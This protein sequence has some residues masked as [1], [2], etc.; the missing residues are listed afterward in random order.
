M[1]RCLW[2]LLCACSGTTTID[3]GA[4]AGIETDAGRDAGPPPEPRAAY[5]APGPHPSGNVRISIEV[6]A[7]TLP[8]EL[9]YPAQ[10][11]ARAAAEAGQSIESFESGDRAAALAG[12]VSAAPDEC[13]RKT[14][15]S[16]AAP[17]AATLDDLPLVVFSHCHACTRFDMAEVAE[18]LATHGIVVAAP[19]HE[20]NTLWDE[21]AS[22]GLMVTTEGLAIRASDISGVLDR[23]LDPTASEVPGDLRGRFGRAAVMGH[24]FGAATTGVLVAGGD[25]R[26]VAG[27]AVAAPI[28][29]LGDV[30]A[31]DVGVPF[32]YLLAREDNSVQEIGNDL[33]RRGFQ[34]I[35][36]SRFLVEVDDA[37]HWSFSDIAGMHTGFMAGCGDGERHVT[38]EPFTYV[39]A[40]QARE[41]AADVAMGFFAIHLLDD[42][43]GATFITRVDADVTYVP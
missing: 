27:L 22:P 19:D 10:D 3:A 34:R 15:R 42:P 8:V 26:F 40:S 1:I 43:G 14:T 20:G 41:L 24:S 4:D 9:W 16:A 38:R 11:S 31:A 30:R 29:V 36:T 33:I 28:D 7:R 25:D 18:R 37:G 5:G 23:L 2:I 21:L 13:T 32:L 6:G 17:P 12:L 35:P 39:D